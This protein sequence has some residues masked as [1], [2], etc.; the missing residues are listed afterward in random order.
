M[1][2]SGVSVF[3]LKQFFDTSF[4]LSSLWLQP[5]LLSLCKALEAWR[6]RTVHDNCS[7]FHLKEQ[8]GQAVRRSAGLRI[9]WVLGLLVTKKLH[10]FTRYRA[11]AIRELYGDLLRAD[12][13]AV[14]F[15]LLGVSNR[16]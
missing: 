7:Y 15:R 5:S 6:R 12:D 16:S 4:G 11:V 9:V 2:K 3:D 10:K 1:C 14:Y 8:L 13:S